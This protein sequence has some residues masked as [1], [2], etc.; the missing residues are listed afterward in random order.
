M[1][2]YTFMHSIEL[3]TVTV[4]IRDTALRCLM[5]ERKA[6]FVDVSCF[7]NKGPKKY[8]GAIKKIDF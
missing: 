6:C 1:K 4:Y 7:Q 2:Y 8:T 5:F 3:E